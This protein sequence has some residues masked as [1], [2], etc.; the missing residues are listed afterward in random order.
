M[1]LRYE[2]LDVFTNVPCGGNPLAVVYGAEGLSDASL[3]K[4]A[5]EFNYSET[6]F[7]LP[8]EDAS[9]TALVR[10]FTPT[11]EL[12]FA[13]H[14]TI[15]TACALGWRGAIFGRDVGDV[16]VLEE[17]S[18]LVP[19]RRDGDWWQLEAPLPFKFGSIGEGVSPADCALCLGI[20]VSDIVRGS[21]GR[22]VSLGGAPPY[23]IVELR[24]A[25]ALARC[26]PNAEALAR[27]GKMYAWVREPAPRDGEPEIRTRM[28]NAKG[29]EDPATGN[30]S[31]CLMGLIA[32]LGANTGNPPDHYR[33]S[34]FTRLI[35][36]G[37]EM[38]RPSLL[39][40]EC[41]QAG[42]YPKAARV[43][44]QCVP[45]MSGELRREHFS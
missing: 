13:G 35:S 15:G 20:D 21:E 16:V 36:Q 24:D 41:E 9:A 7:V 33:A 34:T 38:G 3:Q 31:C 1:A 12:P 28:F 37:V 22:L 32:T 45:M 11:S 6:T 17:Q 10:I 5:R 2:T 39:L 30:A 23:A 42:R 18:G 4:I 19:V 26:T 27:C 29:I 8:P 40:G 44:G 14:P 25:S 43:S